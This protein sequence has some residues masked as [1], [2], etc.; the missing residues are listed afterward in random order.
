MK[1]IIESGATKA[2]WTLIQDSQVKQFQ[3]AGLNFASGDEEFVFRTLEE[4]TVKVLDIT[5]AEVPEEIN[6]Y[7]AGLF[8]SED[9]EST[10]KKLKKAL[11]TRFPGAQVDLENDLMAAARALFGNKPG[12]ACIL[13]TGSN[14]C[15]YDGK[16]ILRKMSSGGFI[17]GDEGSGSALGRAF[18]SDI[19]K[20]LVPECVALAFKEKYDLE[21][22]TVVKNV[23]RG[24]SPAAYLGQFAPDILAF[25]DK[26]HYMRNLVDANFRAFF[27][28][29]ILRIN[30]DGAGEG[31]QL[32][33]GIVGGFAYACKDILTSIANEEGVRIDKILKSPSQ[34]LI[35][36]HQNL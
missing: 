36:Y 12:I 15:V 29:C 6:L 18:I 20:G 35:N 24:A 22:T 2:D 13:G 33:V 32:P 34:E 26:D 25:Y 8:P 27:K 10:Y 21:Y 30:Q 4:A 17:L 7:A 5:D 1:V 31:K 9:P 19:I 23:Y 11:S 16:S 3:T 28:R 14:S